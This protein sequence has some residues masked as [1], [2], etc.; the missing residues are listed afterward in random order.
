MNG[1][2]EPYSDEYYKSIYRENAYIMQC[3]IFSL[4]DSLRFPDEVRAKAIKFTDS[5]EENIGTDDIII[6]I[7]IG[8]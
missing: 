1:H 6:S 8:E 7:P 5:L 4:I 2:V 3:I